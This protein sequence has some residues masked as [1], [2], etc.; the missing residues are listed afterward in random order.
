MQ[1]QA[2]PWPPGGCLEWWWALRKIQ[3]KLCSHRVIPAQLPASAGSVLL[4]K[5]AWSLPNA[6]SGRALEINAL[7]YTQPGTGNSFDLHARSLLLGREL[8]L[9]I[10]LS[11]LPDSFPLILSK[12][13]S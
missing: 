5:P 7:T 3:G 13:L 11:V 12:Q 1:T 4:E 9:I 6:N 10:H 8:G 2:C